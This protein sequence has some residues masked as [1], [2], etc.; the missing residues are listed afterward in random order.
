MIDL[1]EDLDGFLGFYEHRRARL[2]KRL[3]DVLG[4]E[5]GS[6]S[7]TPATPAAASAAPAPAGS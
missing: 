5:P 6:L 1:P 2:R 4:R 7:Q 3:V